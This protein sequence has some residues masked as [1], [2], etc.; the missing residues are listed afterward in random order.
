MQSNIIQSS[1]H[2]FYKNRTASHHD[3]G[4]KFNLFFLKWAIWR[5][6]KHDPKILNTSYHVSK[7]S[8]SYQIRHMT[9]VMHDDCQLRS[10]YVI[11][12]I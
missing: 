8:V 12:S 3:F 2:S 6:S 4:K 5:I 11:S 10:K 7:K 9:V 1:F